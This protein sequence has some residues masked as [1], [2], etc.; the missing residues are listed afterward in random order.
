MP[1]WI[2]KNNFKN[3]WF[4]VGSLALIF[5][6]FI[7][8]KEFAPQKIENKLAS[9]ISCNDISDNQISKLGFKDVADCRLLYK[10]LVEQQ[11]NRC[12][13]E[14]YRSKKLVDTCLAIW[15]KKQYLD[16]SN[17]LIKTQ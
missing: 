9:F 11:I 6:I 17:E 12:N 10:F 8:N 13:D 16:I 2:E 4:I 1:N 15:L 5:L 14:Y 3:A 7:F